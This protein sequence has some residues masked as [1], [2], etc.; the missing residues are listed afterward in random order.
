MTTISA[1]LFLNSILSSHYYLAVDINLKFKTHVFHFKLVLSSSWIH[2]ALM[3]HYV[4]RL[5][6]TFS[7]LFGK[8]KEIESKLHSIVL[9]T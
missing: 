4:F 2:I 6:T 3:S 9:L 1:N 8:G 7:N 5:I